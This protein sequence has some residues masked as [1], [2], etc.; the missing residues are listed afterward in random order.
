MSSQAD[1]AI[2]AFTHWDERGLVIGQ[3]AGT[4]TA[5]DPTLA[6]TEMNGPRT[7]VPDVTRF[8]LDRW[9]AP[10]RIQVNALGAGHNTFLTRGDPVVPALVTE[11]QSPN[12]FVTRATYDGRGNVLTTTAVDPYTPDDTTDAVTRYAWDAVWDFVTK[13]K[14]PAGDSLVLSYDQDDGNRLWQ[15]DG[16][17]DSTRVVF[18]YDNPYSLLSSMLL[19]GGARHEVRYSGQLANPFW[20]RTPLGSATTR[21]QD[22][23]GRDTLVFMP[24][25]RQR[26]IYDAMN[27]VIEQ[28]SIGPT[29][30]GAP[31]ESVLV[32]NRYDAEGNLDT[33]IREASPDVAGFGQILT[34]WTYDW[35][36]HRI[37]EIAPDG[38]RDST[39]YDPAGNSIKVYT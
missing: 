6:F 11:L 19:P 10:V 22:L 3:P 7:E 28:H 25:Q 12:G 8:W 35:A 5:A 20:S 38:K 4:H 29:L 15:Q 33:L 34:Q 31:A 2:T 14:R 24:I 23:M 26:L 27:R 18:H 16:R 37:R 17:G 9:G 36:G 13:I 30:S 21:H 1:L 39:V 32:R